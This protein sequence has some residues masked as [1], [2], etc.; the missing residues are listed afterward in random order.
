MPELPEVE[1]I[2]RSLRPYLEGQVIQQV[3]VNRSSLIK[4]SD[5][6]KFTL[7]LSGQT[8]HH[9]QRRGKY[10]LLSISSDLILII[11]L[12]MTGQLTCQP[13]SV[14]LPKHTHL[15]WK[16]SNNMELRYTDIRRFGKIILTDSDHLKQ[17]S[18]LKD[19]GVEPL[20]KNFTPAVLQAG[21]KGKKGK[22]KS[23]LLDQHIV[24]GLGNIY[25]DEALFLA[26]INPQRSGE[27]LTLP[28]LTALTKAIRS[29]LQSGIEHN[30]TSIQNYVNGQGKAGSN[31]EY[32][33][34]Y[35]QKVCSRCGQEIAKI[36]IAG[37]STFYCPNCQGAEK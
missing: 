32:L 29:V 6:E 22:I 8:I 14:P 7:R 13:P 12:G 26:R 31:Q 28:E 16:L 2:L 3:I 35:A 24:A 33:Q 15:I 9:L 18:G 11:H 25:T 10:M 17:V 37:R 30:G 23:L 4:Q 36:K 20:E 19:L 5:P 21:L 1:T 27:S 34:A